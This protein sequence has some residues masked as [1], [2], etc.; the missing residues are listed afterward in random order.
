MEIIFIRHTTPDIEKGI[1]SEA[2][3][4]SK[5]SVGSEEVFHFTPVI[6]LAW[7][8][9]NREHLNKLVCLLQILYVGIPLSGLTSNPDTRF[10]SMILMMVTG[11]LI[12]VCVLERVDR[13]L[14]WKVI[15]TFDFLYL[16][17]QIGVFYYIILLF[18]QC[19]NSKK[20]IFHFSAH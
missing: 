8:K 11:L 9:R 20:C 15:S 5:D 16:N 7:M 14:A 3:V 19:I 17:V 1:E 2:S 10:Y 12:V 6:Q 18:I 13:K 4:E